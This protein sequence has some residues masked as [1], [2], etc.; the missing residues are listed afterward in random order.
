[1]GLRRVNNCVGRYN[2]KYFVLF[3]LYVTLGES[4]GLLLFLSR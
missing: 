4:Y 1:M 3:L 2:Q